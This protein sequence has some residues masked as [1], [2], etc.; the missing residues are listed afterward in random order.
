MDRRSFLFSAMAAPQVASAYP[1]PQGKRCAVSLSF[2]DARASQID[3]GLALFDKLGIQA[4][5]YVLPRAVEG[6]LAGWK[7]MVAMGQEIGNHSLTHPCTVNYGIGSKGLE[8]FTLA[9]MAANLDEAGL[10]IQEMLGVQARSFAYPC[11]QKF[12]GR[13][14]GTRSYVPLIA[15][16]FS[17]GRGYLDEAANKPLEC[18]FAQLLGTAFDDMDFPAMKAHLEKARASGRWIVFCGHEIGE[19]KYQTTDVAALRALAAYL[20]DPA[21]GYW[22]DTVGNV[23]KRLRAER[24]E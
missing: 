14:A 24:G 19:R 1:W 11:G 3:V 12:V 2:D 5:W 10:Q 20:Q 18:D 7:Q 6:K 13:G 4:T 17:S 22:V 15:E 16:K 23:T 9:E 21:E 8:R